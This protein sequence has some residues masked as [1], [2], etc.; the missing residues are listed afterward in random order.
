MDYGE[1]VGRFYKK[2][3]QKASQ[4]EFRTEKVIRRKGDKLCVKWKGYG[5][6]SISNIFL[7]CISIIKTDY[8]IEIT[9]T[10]NKMPSV[11][12]FV[13]TAALNTRLKTKF[14]ILLI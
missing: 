1:I 3:L 5:N 14:L 10:G 6:Y 13:T 7:S 8:N 12:R 9:Y 11:T 4:T 2:E